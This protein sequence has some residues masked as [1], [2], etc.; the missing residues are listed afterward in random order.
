MARSVEFPTKPVRLIVPFPPGG[1]TDI[2]GRLVAQ[3][4]SE[5]LGHNV[6][7]DN[8]GG[9][10]AIIGTELAARSPADG[11]TLLFAIPA[12]LAVNPG[13]YRNL[14]YQPLRDFTPV[15]QLNV[16]ALLLVAHPSL[17][18][19]SVPA[20]LDRARG[21]AGKINFSSSGTGSA[22]HL[23]MELLQARTGVKMTHVPYKGGGPALNDLIAGHVDVMSGTLMSTLPA[24]RAGR[25]KALA[26][27]TRARSTILP[28]VPALSEH[29]PGYD[30]S[31]W[32]G[33]VV[34]SGTPRA[35]V[36]RLNAE[37]ASLLASGEVRSR[38]ADQGADHVG[39]SAGD[40]G[41]VIKADI[42]KYD[43]LIKRVGIGA[44]V[45]GGR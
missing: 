26:V 18:V 42:E 28:D 22:A 13:L 39:G 9:A 35:V 14:P 3:K 30:M 1:G 17:S 44:Q 45:S 16:F 20:L 43:A 2:V 33:I 12:N 19:A 23:S 11:Y 37:I 7:I 36:E 5:R 29:V 15:I 40:F 31:N 4:L 25:L 34:P 32:Q 41:A 27:T 10:N 21:Q 24:V 38:F 6:V 8:R